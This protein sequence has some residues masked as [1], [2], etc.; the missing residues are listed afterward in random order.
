MFDFMFQIGDELFSSQ[1]TG[2][3]AIG[4]KKQFHN[5][6]KKFFHFFLKK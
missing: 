4:R 1:A 3:A 5:Q 6:V 2:G